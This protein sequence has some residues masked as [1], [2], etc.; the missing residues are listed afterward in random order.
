[1]GLSDGRLHFVQILYDDGGWAIEFQKTYMPEPVV[2]DNVEEDPDSILAAYVREEMTNYNMHSSGLRPEYLNEPIH[3]ETGTRRSGEQLIMRTVCG[4]IVGA[5]PDETFLM[6]VKYECTQNLLRA[7]MKLSQSQS[8]SPYRAA[9]TSE[10]EWQSAT[11]TLASND[12]AF[13]ADG[14][15][16]FPQDHKSCRRMSNC[17]SEDGSLFLDSCREPT[18]P[19]LDAIKSCLG[20][21]LRGRSAEYFECLRA[22]DVKVGCEEQADGSRICY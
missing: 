4:V 9:G 16:V 18:E 11:V 8:D 2:A 10:I 1:V 3:A 22:H 20:R 17:C 5:D 21:G 6:G 12:F 7:I 15:Y 19:E 14:R 13:I